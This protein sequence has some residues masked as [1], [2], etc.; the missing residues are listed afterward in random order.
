[1]SARLPPL[2]LARDAAGFKQRVDKEL[3][4]RQH[5]VHD[6][7]SPRGI[8]NPFAASL[9]TP[10][11]PRQPVNV[12]QPWQIS[13]FQALV[14]HRPTPT[15]S[16]RPTE[17]PWQAALSPR[18]RTTPVLSPISPAS[19]SGGS[20]CGSPRVP[21]A[22]GP[23]DS[24]YGSPLVMARGRADHT[25]GLFSRIAEASTTSVAK[26]SVPLVPWTL[27]SMMRRA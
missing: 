8:A 14:P 27:T 9:Q 1:M 22:R 24:W 2:G 19:S 7:P 5:F 18:T 4:A 10:A 6:Y 25:P 11:S 20:L 16:P 23:D 3:R 17:A 15:L 12:C 21:Q 26:P 13:P